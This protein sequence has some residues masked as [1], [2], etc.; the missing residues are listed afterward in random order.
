MTTTTQTAAEQIA[1]RF[2]NDG[3]SF[4]NAAGENLDVVCEGISGP[5]EYRDGYRTGDTY[6]YKFADGSAIV[7]AGDAWDVE[8]PESFSW[9]GL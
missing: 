6:R 4:N 5:A 1:D 7:V 3:L 9:A 2:H 8:G